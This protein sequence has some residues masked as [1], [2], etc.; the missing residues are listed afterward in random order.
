MTGGTEI[1]VFDANL[2]GGGYV[3]TGIKTSTKFG[4]GVLNAVANGAPLG[5]IPSSNNTETVVEE[6]NKKHKTEHE[7]S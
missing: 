1:H 7:S 6:P 3:L 5:H 2:S 4:E